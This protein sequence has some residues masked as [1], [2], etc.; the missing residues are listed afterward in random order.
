[1]DNCSNTSFSQTMIPTSNFSVSFKEIFILFLFLL[2][3]LYSIVT[4]LH[5][6]SK[7]YRGINHV[8]YYAT[9]KDDGRGVENGENNEKVKI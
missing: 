5:N 8:P 4:F 9:C 2:L 7:N 3:L 1:M 6:W